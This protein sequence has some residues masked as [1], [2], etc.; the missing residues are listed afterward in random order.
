MKL[1]KKGLLPF[2][3]IIV[4]IILVIELATR[5]TTLL[6]TKANFE[7]FMRI[8]YIVCITINLPQ[9]IRAFR[10]AILRY[11]VKRF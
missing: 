3:Y 11:A 1:L 5:F 9:N 6:E 2:L 10:L 4:Y 8:F 7:L